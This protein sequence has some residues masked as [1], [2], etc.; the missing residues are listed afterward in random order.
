[1]S[2]INVEAMWVHSSNLTKLN[3]ARAFFCTMLFKGICFTKK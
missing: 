1:M 2:L 3:K